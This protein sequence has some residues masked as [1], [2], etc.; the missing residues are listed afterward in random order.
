MI[1]FI[2]E[3][4]R[5]VTDRGISRED[6]RPNDTSNRGGN[7]LHLKNLPSHQ[8]EGTLEAF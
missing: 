5:L 2:Q 7:K 6:V 1:P 8:V 4:D 3:N